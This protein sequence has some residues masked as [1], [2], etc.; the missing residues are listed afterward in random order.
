MDLEDLLDGRVDVILARRFAVEDLDGE[1]STRDGEGWSS[2]VE[3][4]E[5]K[6]KKEGEEDVNST[7][8]WRDRERAAHLLRV[9]GRRSDDEFEISTT[10]KN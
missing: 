5:L 10:G 3:L 8:L 9:H 1:G 7:R 2:T 6:R 4:R